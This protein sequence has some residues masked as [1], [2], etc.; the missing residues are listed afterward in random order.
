MTTVV[1]TGANGFVGTEVC[2]KLAQSSYRVLR[3]VRETKGTSPDEMAVGDIG[4]DTYWKS[5]LEKT[6][7]VVHLA[8]RVH[9]MH[10]EDL[11]QIKNYREVNFS[12]TMAL[13]RQSADA[14]VKRFIFISSIKVNGESTVIGRPFTA[15]DEP[16][17]LDPYGASKAETEQALLRLSESTGLEVVIIRPV[18][19]YGPGV[20]ANFQSLME[21]VDMGIPLPLGNIHN[22]RSLVALDNLVDLIITCIEHPEAVNQVFLVSDGEDL[23]TSDLLQRVGTALGRPARLIDVPASLIKIAAKLTGKSNVSQRLLGS[24]QVDIT[25]TQDIL[26]WSPPVS[27]NEALKKTAQSFLDN[28]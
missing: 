3:V 12:G 14:G 4:P 25:K 11:T 7:V 13:A 5:I 1:I 16:A 9:V 26:D 24:L 2:N 17:P 8:A 20:R 10:A 23:S 6:D 22:K 19:V 27:V 15:D 28:K 21:L 18:L